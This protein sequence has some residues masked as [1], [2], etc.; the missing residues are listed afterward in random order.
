MTFFSR[1]LL[2]AANGSEEA[3]LAARL[4]AEWPRAL[5]VRSRES[6]DDHAR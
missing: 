5:V 2:L 1:E 3:E 6:T 4:A